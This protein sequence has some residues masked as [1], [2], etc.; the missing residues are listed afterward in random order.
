MRSASR[1]FRRTGGFAVKTRSRSAHG[2]ETKSD[3]T[4][5]EGLW[6]MWRAKVEADADQ[7]VRLLSRLAPRQ[8]L[9]TA[10]EI[11]PPGLL[12]TMGEALERRSPRLRSHG[13]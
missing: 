9:A 12:Q 6:R 2:K 8:D 5:N 4:L 13:A 3:P 7:I 10:Q 1:F 11:R